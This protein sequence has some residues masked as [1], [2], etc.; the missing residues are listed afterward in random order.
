MEELSGIGLQF[1]RNCGEGNLIS[2][3]ESVVGLPPLYA[4]RD[5][6]A[7]KA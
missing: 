2:S 6:V 4:H 1:G 7:E 5:G 3:M